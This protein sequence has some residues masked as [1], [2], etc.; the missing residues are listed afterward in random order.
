MDPSEPASQ[1]ARFLNSVPP[2]FIL[3][4]STPHFSTPNPRRI[5][6]KSKGIDIDNDH[7]ERPVLATL[8][9][10]AIRE[11]HRYFYSPSLRFSIF[12]QYAT[13]IRT[14][15]LLSQRGKNQEWIRGLKEGSI[16]FCIM[17]GVMGCHQFRQSHCFSSVD[18]IYTT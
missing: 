14:P 3:L 9:L 12:V 10:R 17:V 16:C 15:R 4:S 18:L 1:P 6:G 8:D 5:R 11:L 2:L 7:A 13:N